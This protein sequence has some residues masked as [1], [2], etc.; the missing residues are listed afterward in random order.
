MKTKCQVIAD[1]KISNSG[2]IFC[3][4]SATVKENLSELVRRR[5]KELET[6]KAAVAAKAG[7]SRTYITDIANGTGN[8]QSGEYRPSPEAVLK[9]AKALEVTETE[10]INSIGYSSKARDV[11][12]YEILEGMNLEFEKSFPYPE[13]AKQKLIEAIRMVAAGAVAQIQQIKQPKE[14]LIEGNPEELLKEK[15]KS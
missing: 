7:L 8:T 13:S 5:I 10:I 1:N 11:E 14:Y 6:S 12:F 9:L 15:T 4:L 3:K 2:Q